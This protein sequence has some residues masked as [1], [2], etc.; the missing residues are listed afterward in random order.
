MFRRQDERGYFC[1]E[2]SPEQFVSFLGVDAA[3]W[4]QVEWHIRKR[5]EGFDTASR[6]DLRSAVIVEY[7]AAVKRGVTRTPWQL[8]HDVEDEL[9]LSDTFPHEPNE[10]DIA[11]TVL[12]GAALIRE[13]SVDYRFLKRWDQL[14]ANPRTKVR[15]LRALL[16]SRDQHT[17]EALALRAKLAEIPRSEYPRIVG[18]IAHAGKAWVMTYSLSWLGVDVEACA[19]HYLAERQADEDM[20]EPTTLYDVLRV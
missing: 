11:A 2:C 17:R 16:E 9:V 12:D 18:Q 10:Y 15:E 8:V 1:P 14:I 13:L 19:K 3:Y 6:H 20:E 4:R 7:F 5:T